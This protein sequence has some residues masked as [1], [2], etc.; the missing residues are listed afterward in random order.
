[1]TDVGQELLISG[2]SIVLVQAK[3]GSSL[4]PLLNLAGKA[5]SNRVLCVP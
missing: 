4:F 2:H 1:M 5:V 3:Q